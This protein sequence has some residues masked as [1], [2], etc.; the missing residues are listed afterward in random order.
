MGE[1]KDIKD[2]A[3]NDHLISQLEQLLEYAKSGEMRSI[4]WSASWDDDNT[5]HGW[6]I[7]RRTWTKPLIGEMTM[8]AH[9]VSVD[10]DFRTGRGA[11]SRELGEY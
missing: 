3:P 2:R 1:L 10:E 8:V 7:D 4:I 5:S 9:D 6:S 11:L